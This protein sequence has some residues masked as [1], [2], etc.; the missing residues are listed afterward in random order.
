MTFE[1]EAMH[2][3]TL[4]YMYVQD[5][6][7]ECNNLIPLPFLKTNEISKEANWVSVPEQTVTLGANNFEKED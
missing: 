7:I 6:T 5:E 3:E 2:I 1:H 4:L